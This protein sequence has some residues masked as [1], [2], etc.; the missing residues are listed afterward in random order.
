LTKLAV[1][2]LLLL[3]ISKYT[4][5]KLRK[6]AF[7]AFV[8]VINY[9]RDLAFHEVSFKLVCVTNEQV[10]TAAFQPVPTYGCSVKRT[11]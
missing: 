11:A 2:I 10:V 6:T 3:K 7:D 8:P 5:I 9:D 4:K 1:Y